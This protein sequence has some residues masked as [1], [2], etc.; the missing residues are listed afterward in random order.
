MEL[1][2]NFMKKE[3]TM[4]FDDK[5]LGLIKETF[6]DNLP[7]LKAIRK[8]FLQIPL[9]EREDV[10]LRKSMRGDVMKIMRKSFLPEVDGNAPINQVIDLWMTIKIDD[11]TPEE[12]EPFITAR[13]MVIEYI[14]QQLEALGGNGKEE[15][16]FS[17]FLE[18]TGVS[19]KYQYINLITRNTV[20]FHVESQIN[21]INILANEKDETKEEAKKRQ[22]KDS[23]K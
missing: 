22:K 1:T 4:R 20:V 2:N 17:S 7:I 21:D 8:V 14:N 10:E 16:K 11:K 3:Q 9:T 6:K 13:G 5:E 12:A 15:I 19:P 23:S 18:M